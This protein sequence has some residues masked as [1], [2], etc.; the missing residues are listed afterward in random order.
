VGNEC[1]TPVRVFSKSQS[2]HK[3]KE[4]LPLPAGRVPP[5]PS[6]LLKLA[7]STYRSYHYLPR[8]RARL[9]YHRNPGEQKSRLYFERTAS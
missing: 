2:N 8:L 1:T 9:S 3:D 6:E 7:I 5:V 4:R